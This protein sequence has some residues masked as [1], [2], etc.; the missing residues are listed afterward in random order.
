MEAGRTPVVLSIAGSDSGGGAGIQADLKA[1]AALGVHGTTAITAITAQNTLGVTAIHPIP[2]EVIVAQVDAVV[3]DIGVDAV[4]IGM[5][6]TRETTE[7]VVA[8]LAHV[9]PVPI[10]VD[11][12][13]VSESGAT[14]LD[15]GAREALV[16]RPAAAGDGA[17]PERPR[18]AGARRCGGGGGS[19]AFRA[20]RDDPLAGPVGRDRHRRPRRWRRPPRRRRRADLDPGADASRR[21]R[22]RVGMHPQLEPRRAAGARVSPSGGRRRGA[23]ARRAR[24]SRTACATSAQARGPWTRST[25][26]PGAR[27][28]R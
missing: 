22:A 3:A 19:H 24:R 6:G 20:R 15:D 8:A 9:P 14:L 2:P 21:R 4:K 27:A 17:D 28:R 1:F 11:P 25:S 10:V 7:A 16:R 18:G 23:A 5:L 26:P 13:M 12:V